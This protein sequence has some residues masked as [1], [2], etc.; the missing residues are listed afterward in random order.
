MVPSVASLES[1]AGLDRSVVMFS[2]D[3]VPPRLRRLISTNLG[4]VGL[5]AGFQGVA[6][7][8]LSASHAASSQ[9]RTLIG[10]IAQLRADLLA[11]GGESIQALPRFLFY[12]SLCLF[13]RL[14]G[15]CQ[16]QEHAGC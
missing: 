1:A 6:D 10:Q 5:A 8:F 16:G 11:T 7:L 13:P 3:H 12:E 2:C 15:K 9:V 14:W 4:G